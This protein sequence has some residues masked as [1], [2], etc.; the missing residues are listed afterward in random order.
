MIYGESLNYKNYKSTC[1]VLSKILLSVSTSKRK[2]LHKE[3]LL[4]IIYDLEKLLEE[5]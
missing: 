5:N 3:K 4:K 1:V 2:T